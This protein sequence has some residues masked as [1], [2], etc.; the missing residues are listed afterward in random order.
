[1][2]DYIS[3]FAGLP[4]ELATMLIAALPLAELRGALPVALSVYHLSWWSAYFWS[5]LGNILPVIFILWLLEP[6]SKYLIQ[7]SKLAAK[8][9]DLLFARTK[10]KF[11]D[12]YKKYGEL[13]LVIFVAIPLPMTGAWTG[14]IA[15]FLFGIPY[16]KSLSSITLGVLIAGLIVTALYQGVFWGVKV[17]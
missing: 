13:A 12:K 8:F 10:N 5:V 11:A 1:M 4:P 14:A 3:W 7:H 16:K 2:F 9:F 15:A 6:V 17:F